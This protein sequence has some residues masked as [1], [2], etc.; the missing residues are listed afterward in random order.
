MNTKK[1]MKHNRPIFGEK[2]E[3]RLFI[4]LS[5]KLSDRFIVQQRCQDF[6]SFTNSPEFVHI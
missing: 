6:F 5:G 3:L 2:A 1:I 4:K